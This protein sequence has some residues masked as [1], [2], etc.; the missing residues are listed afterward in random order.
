MSEPRKT[1][2]DA[3]RVIEDQRVQDLAP[4]PLTADEEA[5]IKGGLDSSKQS[6]G[7]LN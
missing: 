5:K 7:S 1:N 4:A 6:L 3:K 2:E